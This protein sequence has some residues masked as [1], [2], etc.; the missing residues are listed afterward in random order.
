[1]TLYLLL[2]Y[3]YNY[4]CVFYRTKVQSFFIKKK[5]LISEIKLN[6]R[7]ISQFFCRVSS[8]E[9]GIDRGWIGNNLHQH[10]KYDTMV[11]LDITGKVE[12]AA[13]RTESFSHVWC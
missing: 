12:L 10:L 8:I 3:I 1:M 13:V 11:S 5:K 9:I 4:S 6:S 2:F 7:K